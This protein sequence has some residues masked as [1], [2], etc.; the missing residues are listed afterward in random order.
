M[1]YLILKSASII[2][3]ISIIIIIIQSCCKETFRI[4]SKVV[5][6]GVWTMVGQG[7]LKID[8]IKSNFIVSTDFEIILCS[9]GRNFSLIN[10]AY[11]T[12]C[13]KTFLNLLIPQSFTLT[14]DKPFIYNN[15]TILTN[16]NLI[17]L[18]NVIPQINEG[19]SAEVRFPQEF[20]NN[21]K[22]QPGKYK[23]TLNGMTND[24]IKLTNSIEIYIDI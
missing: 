1:K 8:T 12:S 14:I 22:F 9:N 24:S 15:D 18:P 19:G 6:S 5:G 13:K 7:R 21:V 10:S 20:I 23:F 2:I 3:L 16:E 11:A 17:K 4:S